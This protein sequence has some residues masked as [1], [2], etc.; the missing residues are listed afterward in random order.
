MKILC[1]ES[2]FPPELDSSRLS[3]EFARE[4]VQRNH[5]VTVVTV[6]PRKLWVKQQFVIQEGKFF[7][8]DQIG[9]VLV[10]R[11]WPQFKG[12]SI[13]KR[14]IEYLILPLS[15]LLGGLIAGRKDVIH[16]QSPPLS[17]AFSAC[18]LKK[19]TR[20]PFILRIQ[21]IHPDALLKMGLLKNMVLIKLMEFMESFVY[22]C[23]SHI[24]VISEG[25][26]RHVL[27]KGI[28]EKKVSLLP[29]WADIDRIKPPDRNDFRE[30]MGL[31]DKFI[32]T[33]AGTMSWP[34]DLETVVES[35]SVLRNYHDITFLMVGDGVKKE[36]LVKR[37]RGLGLDNMIFMPL[38][39]RDKYFKILYTSDVCII[40]LKKQFTSPTVP[41][42]MLEIMACGKP[43][44]TNVPS[45]SDVQRIIND[46]ECGIW[47]KPENPEAFSKAVLTLY[48]DRNIAL[49][50]GKNGLLYVKNHFSLRV[51]MN[52]Y[53]KLLNS[54]V[55]AAR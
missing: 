31:E 23:A 13:I 2:G 48:D 30:R 4:L 9:G 44:I 12:K 6:F 26:R 42:K 54:F 11:C 49:K 46:A 17:L 21:D 43:M 19:L 7:Y 45:N 8:W 29:N 33:Y 28:S 51:C 25:Y 24:T 37:S 34:Q 3:Y 39:P 27:A 32:I 20:T 10:L 53:E 18:I 22:L 35:A 40:P 14:A 36:T 55:K 1:L 15:L 50:L 38:Q 47:V 5:E 16:C 41:S 52:R